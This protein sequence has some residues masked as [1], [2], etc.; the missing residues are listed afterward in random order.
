MASFQLFQ[1]CAA[2]AA[3]LTVNKTTVALSAPG[4]LA[5]V[6]P[7]IPELNIG[8]IAAVVKKEIVIGATSSQN[9]RRIKELDR[10]RLENSIPS[11]AHHGLRMLCGG[12]VPGII[13]CPVDTSAGEFAC[14]KMSNIR[15]NIA[16]VQKLVEPILLK[17]VNS[18]KSGYFDKVTDPL[19]ELQLKSAP[20][21]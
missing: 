4:P 9:G 1:I 2:A 17:L 12:Q 7:W 10:R 21:S 11:D 15:L 18:D 14:A 3:T 13:D 19:L 20:Q 16:M 6:K 5:D 8:E